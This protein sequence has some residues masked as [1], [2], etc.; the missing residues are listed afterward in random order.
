MPLLGSLGIDVPAA[1]F[2]AAGAVYGTASG[3]IESTMPAP[4]DYMPRVFKVT[5]MRHW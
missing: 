4:S 2:Y 3:I 5:G 1:V